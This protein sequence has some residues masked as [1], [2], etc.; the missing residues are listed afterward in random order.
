MNKFCD[1][2]CG[3]KCFQRIG[4]GIEYSS[5]LLLTCLVQ[6]C[7]CFKPKKVST[8]EYEGLKA[9]TDIIDDVEEEILAEIE[10]KIEKE[11]AA[12]KAAEEKK[13]SELS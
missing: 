1:R 3:N 8:P 5:S 9:L 2:Q 10:E 7:E 6:K 12:E 11:L 4:D 13:E